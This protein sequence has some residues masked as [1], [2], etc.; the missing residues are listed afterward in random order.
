MSGSGLNRVLR[1]A[2]AALVV[3]PALSYGEPASGA[4]MPETAA[5]ER[6]CE[7]KFT[8]TLTDAQDEAERNYDSV[9][10][11]AAADILKALR[12]KDVGVSRKYG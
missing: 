6:K 8:K 10:F 3:G 5:G 9:S 1:I 11:S 7:D 4:G 12:D 2:A